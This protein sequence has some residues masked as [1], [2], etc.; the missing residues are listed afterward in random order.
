MVDYFIFLYLPLSV[1]YERAA[2]DRSLFGP[3]GRRWIERKLP[4]VVTN[5]VFAVVAGFG[6]CLI[7]LSVT[8]DFKM[9]LVIGL[10]ALPKH[11][12]SVVVLLVVARILHWHVCNTVQRV[13]TC[14][15]MSWLLFTL[16]TFTLTSSAIQFTV[17]CRYGARR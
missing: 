10:F 14:L 4:T 9:G 5:Y 15:H 13:C 8:R 3:Q 7:M 12:T 2:V 16:C 11:I 1:W 17:P 6:S